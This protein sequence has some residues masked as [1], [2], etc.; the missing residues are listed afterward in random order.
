M[1]ELG[2]P[3][4]RRAFMSGERSTVYPYSALPEG[5][6]LCIS[7]YGQSVHTNDSPNGGEL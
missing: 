3:G 4:K 6:Y 1:L 2:V 5:R 7:G